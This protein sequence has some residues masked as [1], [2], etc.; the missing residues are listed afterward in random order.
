MKRYY[1]RVAANYSFA[2]EQLDRLGGFWQDVLLKLP[3]RFEAKL[4]L[5]RFTFATFECTSDSTEDIKKEIFAAFE[6]LFPGNPPAHMDFCL[7]DGT[8]VSDAMRSLYNS[9]YGAPEVHKLFSELTAA[10]PALHERKAEDAIMRLNF[11]VAADAGAGYTELLRVFSRVFTPAKIYTGEEQSKGGYYNERI[12]GETTEN[13]FTSAADI[14]D[15]L[16]ESSNTQ[17]LPFGIDISYYLN[18][19]HDEEFRTFLKRLE[20]FRDEYIFVFRI[21]FLEKKAFDAV[22]EKLSDIL[23]VKTIKIPPLPDC[24]IMETVWNI[25]T[26][27]GYSINTGIFPIVRE[28][29]AKEKTDGRFYGFKTAEKIAYELILTKTINNSKAEFEGLSPDR[30]EFSIEDAEGI[31]GKNKKKATGYDAFKDLIGMENIE[32]R[33]REIITQVKV[34][35]QNDK[36]DKPSIHMRFTGAPGTGK[37]TVAR[38]MGQIMKEEGILRKGGFFEYTG[39][40]LIA[41]YVGQTAP[42][43]SAICRDAYGSVLFIDEAYALYDGG[44]QSNDFGKEAITTL[45]S[46]MENHRDDMTIIMAGY[47][48]EMD[49]LM[50]ANPGL[51]SRMPYVVDFP[52]YTREQ[53]YEIYM[54]MLKKAFK[55]TPELEDA[56]HKYFLALSDEYLSSKE[57]ANA[58]FVRNLYERTW[59][60]TALRCSLNGTDD[61]VVT[62]EDFIAASSEKE[63]T[64]KLMHEKRIGF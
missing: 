26:D 37:T 42:K 60:K 22:E 1:V 36:L 6:E 50:T 61:Y 27:K 53:L 14:V 3:A 32:K 19:Q 12:V 25:L 11:L 10:L 24:V 52:N 57:F 35:M 9:Y 56:V 31:L 46:E 2:D 29:I 21:P 4:N 64:E 45:I 48:D 39:R 47:I 17:S 49:T 54:L 33:I 20:R 38:I 28:K 23:P 41:E 18:G 40:D 44:K 59:S 8:P 7:A 58:R 34:S 43:T 16:D 15:E 51:R 63:F 5:W 13:G 62:K 30:A 55:Y